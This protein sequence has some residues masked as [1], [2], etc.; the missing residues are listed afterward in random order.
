MEERPGSPGAQGDP[1]AAGVPQPGERSGAFA[2]AAVNVL[3][4]TILRR[5]MR[6]ACAVGCVSIVVPA[7]FVSDVD[8]RGLVVGVI[9]IVVVFVATRAF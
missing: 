3:R 9:A 8:Q 4:E 5:I 7:L 2:A 6:A 1:L